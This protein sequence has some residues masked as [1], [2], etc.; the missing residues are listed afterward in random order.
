MLIWG[1]KLMQIIMIVVGVTVTVICTAIIIL[2]KKG[3][4]LID[5][6]S[7]VYKVCAFFLCWAICCTLCGIFLIPYFI[8]NVAIKI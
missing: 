3:I 8:Q 1:L 4:I 7:W 2:K 5:K 6:G